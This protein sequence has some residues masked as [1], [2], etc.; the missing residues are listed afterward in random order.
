MR[1]ILAAKGETMRARSGELIH[2][3]SKFGKSIFLILL[4]VLAIHL[5]VLLIDYFIIKKPLVINMKNDFIGTAFSYPMIPIIMAYVIFSIISSYM[6]HKM[7]RAILTARET[8]RRTEKQAILIGMLQNITGILGEHITTHNSEIQRWIADMKMK[9]RQPPK[10][11]EE[12]SR[13]ISEVLGALSE[14]AFLSGKEIS[15]PDDRAI[16]NM[17]DI[18]LLLKK[19]ITEKNLA[20]TASEILQDAGKIH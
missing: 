9:N 7:K 10:A 5:S 3:L 17:Q 12:S 19:R 16:R 13:K 8:E 4:S 20:A 14:I 15:S 18:E 2:I 11:V 1:R 6:W